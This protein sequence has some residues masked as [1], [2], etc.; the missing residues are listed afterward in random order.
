MNLDDQLTL[1]PLFLTDRE[2]RTC[3]EVKNLIDGFYK[4]G[5]GVNPSSYS[6]ECKSCAIKRVINRRRKKDKSSEY[7]YPDW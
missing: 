6:Y 3:G 4:K 7:H 1:G 5:P 2:C